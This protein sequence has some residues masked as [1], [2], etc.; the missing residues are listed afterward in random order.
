[1]RLILL[2]MLLSTFIVTA[3]GGSGMDP[4]GGATTRLTSDQG[5]GTDPDGA[6]RGSL[7]I[8]SD[9]AGGADPNG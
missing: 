7:I 3:R 9:G 8:H 1:M 5:G 6:P 2:L 4:N